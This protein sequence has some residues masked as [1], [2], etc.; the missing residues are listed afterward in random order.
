MDSWKRFD[1]TLPDKRKFYSDLN[2]KGITDADYEHAKR[3]YIEFKNK[4]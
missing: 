1:E 3:V 2:M 4:I